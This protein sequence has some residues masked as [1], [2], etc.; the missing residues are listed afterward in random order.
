MTENIITTLRDNKKARWTALLIV[1]FT[2]MTGYYIN[3]VI[4]PL[5]PLLEDYFNWSSTDFGFWNSAY[6]WF[7][8][9]FLMLIFGGI[10]LDKI[11]IRFTGLSATLTMVVGTFLQFAAIR[12]LWPMDGAT[13]GIS[14]QILI[15]G[16][17]FGIF[18]VG[19]EIAGITVSK[20][21]VKWFQGKE[22]ALAMGLEM[23]MA[24]MGTALAL[25]IPAPIAASMLEKGALPNVALSA[26]LMLGLGLLVAGFLA[27]FYYTFKD[28]ELDRSLAA[29]KLDTADS[30]SED[31]FKIKDIVII[32]KNKGFWL[33]A[34]LCVLFYSGVFPFLYYA[35]DLMVNKYGVDPKFAGAIPSLLPFG[36]I[37]LTPFFGNIYDKKGKGAS[38]MLLGSVMLLGVHS[39]FAI[40]SI[41]F[42]AFAV[43]LILLLGV[44]FS[45]VPSAMWPSVPKIIPE[46]LLGSAYAMIFWV[47][48][49]GL[50]SV[51]LLIGWVLDKYCITNADMVAQGV[52]PH[53]DYTLPMVIFAALGLLAIGVA[54]LLKAEDK[55]KGYGLEMPNIKR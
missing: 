48:N 15:G 11:G 45:L 19:I 10:I 36:T 4:S 18:G 33:I 51:P 25:A 49:I 8:V 30:L 34:L 20:I 37:I 24:R 52:K 13:F 23:A 38:I 44:T 32:I 39:L 14:N 55:K 42:A 9:F 28:K 35:A 7:N 53:Y 46:R 16:L 54:L 41:N 12:Q 43:L 6:G 2:M 31:E 50:M 47:Q 1:S 40:P 26:P 21:I 3:Y 5:K 29:A 27:F 17:G 22:L